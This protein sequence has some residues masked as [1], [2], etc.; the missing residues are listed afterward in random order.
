M[1]TIKLRTLL[2][3]LLPAPTGEVPFTQSG[4][5]GWH[6]PGA[7]SASISAPTL[8][9]PDESSATLAVDLAIEAW[10]KQR[11]KSAR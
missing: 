5:Q 9:D 1:T 7:D 2:D 4:R 10:V 3:A 8:H 11:P 6:S